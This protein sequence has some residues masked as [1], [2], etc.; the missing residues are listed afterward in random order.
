[1]ISHHLFIEQCKKRGNFYLN[2]ESVTPLTGFPHSGLLGAIV[3][4]VG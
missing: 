4:L 1:M 2:P 3:S